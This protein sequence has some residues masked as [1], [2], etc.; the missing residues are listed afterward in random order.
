MSSSADNS[1]N[2]S[3]RFPAAVDSINNNS[4][5][6]NDASQFHNSYNEVNEINND[7]NSQVNNGN[8]ITFHVLVSLKEAAKIIGPQGNTIETIR[9]ENDIKIGISPREKSCSDRLLNVSGPPRQVANSLGQVLRVLTTDYEP[10]EHV[11]KHL[12]FMLPPASKEEIEDPEKWK[13][14]G[15]LRLICT[16]PQISSVI[17]Q[18]GAKIKK[19]IETHTVK[20]VASKHFLPDSKDRVLEIQGFPT[21]VANCINEIAEL[22]IQDDVHVPPRTL[23]RYYPHSKHTKEI[24]VSQTLAI[25]K[26]FVGALLGVGGNRIANLRKFTKT[27]IVIG[28]DPTENGDRIFTV[29][30]N[31]QKSVKLAQTMLLKNL[32][33]EKKR[34]EEHEASL[35]DGSSV[36]AAA[37]ASAATSISA[38]GANQNDSI[39][40]PV[41]DNESPVVFTE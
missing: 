33:V 1:N 5:S 11:F 24:Q 7:T 6:I 22:F 41:S 15:N 17:G 23:P 3:S 34:R 36:P 37:A 38:S 19:L 32:E 2:S 4:N 14:I 16:N 35:K 28:Q 39:H 8:N 31:D 26:E 25:P 10:E 13:Q 40:T 9:R 21:S 30:G 27:K 12:R 18:Q 29:W 20:L